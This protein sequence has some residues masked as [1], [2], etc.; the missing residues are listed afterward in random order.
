ML[1]SRQG[2]GKLIPLAAELNRIPNM[3]NE[4]PELNP[5]WH[6]GS[7]GGHVE[8]DREFENWCRENSPAF[9]LAVAQKERFAL[10]NTGSWYLL[11]IRD[12]IVQQQRLLVDLEIAKDKIPFKNR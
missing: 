2:C 1:Q 5:D 4:P 8:G 12:L 6:G 3:K 10:G 9:R 11:A 7:A